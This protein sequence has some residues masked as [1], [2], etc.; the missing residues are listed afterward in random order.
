[1]SRDRWSRR[2]TS[3]GL[4]DARGAEGEHVDVSDDML[5]IT[6]YLANALDPAGVQKV[7]ARLGND[8][9]FAELANPLIEL[10]DASTAAAPM[11][12][13]ELLQSWHEFRDSAGMQPLATRR[14][15]APKPAHSD[16]PRFMPRWATAYNVAAV[17]A[18]MVVAVSEV[19]IRLLPDSRQ[20]VTHI[21]E[22]GAS[23]QP[24]TL[25]NGSRIGLGPSSRLV[26]TDPASTRH[27]IDVD[28]QGTALFALA[29]VSVGAYRVITP[30]AV[31]EVTGTTFE[32]DAR[33]PAETRVRL[34]E[35]KVRVS[36]R[37]TTGGEIT[38]MPGET[39]IAA[40]GKAPRRVE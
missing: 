30:A 4:E 7:E 5:L 39:V 18:I 6:D 1:M 21:V 26:Y 11:S 2:R 36:S 37:A 17:A 19:A 22:G 38:M 33:N 32:V 3:N 10:W 23:G 28:L 40:W 16:Q 25:A 24:V 9:A 35:G 14:A 20:A 29:S 8:P 15:L 12:H 34:I 31:I 13:E 27:G